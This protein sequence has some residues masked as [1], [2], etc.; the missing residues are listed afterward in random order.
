MYKFICNELY[1][2]Y[3]ISIAH[4]LSDHDIAEFLKISIQEY[5]KFLYKFNGVSNKAY[6][7]DV[8]FS[9]REDISGCIKYLNEVFECYIKLID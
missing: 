7:N 3:Y 4:S 8:F 9:N 1:D 6:N 5:R 2:K